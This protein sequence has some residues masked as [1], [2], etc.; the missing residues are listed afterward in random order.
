MA[1]GNYDAQGVYHYGEDDVI[2]TWSAFMNLLAA[3]VGAVVLT[4]TTAV[5][6]LTRR[7]VRLESN[8]I[9]KGT[10]TGATIPAAG[11][12]LGIVGSLTIPAVPYARSV[13]LNYGAVATS[14]GSGSIVG[15]YVLRAGVALGRQART[16]LANQTAAQSL[17]DTIPANTAMSYQLVANGTAAATITSDSRFTYLEVTT[18]TATL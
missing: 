7:A 10:A 13:L 12:T 15:V 17:S 9:T 5:T 2:T 11:G 16:A 18:E 3:S 6:D 14:L 1:T 4:L 8:T